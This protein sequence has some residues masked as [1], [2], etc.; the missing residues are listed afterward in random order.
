MRDAGDQVFPVRVNNVRPKINDVNIDIDF[1][2][3][4]VLEVDPVR[5]GKLCS[6]RFSYGEGKAGVVAVLQGPGG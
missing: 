1:I 6:G 5:S 4:R 3:P 2:D